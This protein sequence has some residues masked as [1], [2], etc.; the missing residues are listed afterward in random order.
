M[1]GLSGSGSKSKSKSG[2]RYNTDFM[3]KF[4]ER[5]GSGAVT[6]NDVIAMA[7][8]PSSV[9]GADERRG[10]SN[11]GFGERAPTYEAPKFALGGGDYNRLEGSLFRSQFD[12]VAREVE[13]QRG[14]QS[15]EMSARLAGSGL[16]ASGAGIGQ[17]RRLDQD[18]NQTL[19]EQASDAAN[20]ATAGRYDLESREGLANADR[21]ASTQ[22]LNAQSLAQSRASE[23]QLLGLKADDLARLDQGALNRL[24]RIMQ[25]YRDAIAPAVEAGRFSKGKSSSGGGRVY[26]TQPEPAPAK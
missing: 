9:L 1:G 20:R 3:D 15:D 8:T 18:F 7:P 10:L 19:T 4:E 13:R 24:D 5:Y 6:R 23:L 21:A 26:P 2:T 25:A 11:L 22:A 14:L 16:F 17:Q 12:P